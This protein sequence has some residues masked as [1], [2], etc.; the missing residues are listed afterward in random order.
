VR[1]DFARRAADNL[2][3]LV[4]VVQGLRAAS[5]AVAW[6]ELHALASKEVD[7]GAHAKLI[8]VFRNLGKTTT[9]NLGSICTF[10]CHMSYLC[11]GRVAVK[12]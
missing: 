12:P 7:E 8:S 10:F 11:T 4:E 3:G 5:A 1:H 6:R 2:A 9:S